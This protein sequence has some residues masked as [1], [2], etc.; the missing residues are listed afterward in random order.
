MK[1]RRFNPLFDAPRRRHP[2]AR[3]RR[4]TILVL[5]VAVLALLAVIGTVYVVAARTDR[6]TSR[7]MNESLN[8]KLARDAFMEQVTQVIGNAMI[9]TNGK[10]GGYTARNFDVPGPNQLWL[11]VHMH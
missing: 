9:D 11:A 8:L 6:A 2:I 5:V 7:A 10:V 3:H 4:G 1:I